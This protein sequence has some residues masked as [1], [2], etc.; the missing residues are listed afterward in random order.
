[1]GIITRVRL[2]FPEVSG[3][4][5]SILYSSTQIEAGPYQLSYRKV[6]NLIS[7]FSICISNFRRNYQIVLHSSLL[8]FQSRYLRH[9][10]LIS[11]KLFIQIDKNYFSYFYKLSV[12]KLYLWIPCSKRDII[13]FQMQIFVN[14]STFYI[15]STSKLSST[16]TE[17]SLFCAEFGVVIKFFLLTVSTFLKLSIS[18]IRFNSISTNKPTQRSKSS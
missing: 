2:L 8:M 9:Q 15:P 13:Y 4:V 5:T 14:S 17:A 6:A 18:Q 7:G 10:E 1:M 16:F 12:E 3:Q 11:K